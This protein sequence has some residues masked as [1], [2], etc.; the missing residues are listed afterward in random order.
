M[1]WTN[2]NL[3]ESRSAN[4]KRSTG[5]KQQKQPRGIPTR[6]KNKIKDLPTAPDLP[7]YNQNQNVS[8]N[9]DVLL[10]NRFAADMNAL[11]EYQSFD[12]PNEERKQSFSNNENSNNLPI[13]VK[14]DESCLK[15]R[16]TEVRKKKNTKSP[17]QFDTP[18]HF[19]GSLNQ[20]KICTPR[21]TTSWSKGSKV[22]S[23]PTT[24]P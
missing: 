2:G 11:A 17:S 9:V 18:L 1:C 16:T 3:D 6:N 8:R 14:S 20:P 21:T 19:N 22:V 15:K 10:R 5:G 12:E 13:Y 7:R 4:R 24:S 23:S